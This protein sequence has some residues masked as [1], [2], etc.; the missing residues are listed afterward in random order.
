MRPSIAIAFGLLLAGCHQAPPPAATAFHVT[1]SIQD[2]MQSIVDPAADALWESVSST[3]TASGVEEKKPESDDDWKVLR[4]Q[5]IQLAESANLLAVD[6][7]PV[8]HPGRP[9]E[10]AH[11]K[12]TLKP[13]DIQARISKDRP[14]FLAHARNLQV[15]AESAIAAIDAKDLAAFAAAGEQIDRA[16]EACHLAYWYPDDKRPP[17]LAGPRK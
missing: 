1:A 13:E 4:H 14:A 6:G 8:A 17:E 10:D 9:L 3:V 5:A 15:S 7:R 16:C 12:V 2:I 11:T